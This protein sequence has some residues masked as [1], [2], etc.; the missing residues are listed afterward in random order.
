MNSR[1]SDDTRA[2]LIE[3]ADRLVYQKGFKHTSLADI[4]RESSVPL[5]NVYYHF[6]TKDELG[7]ALVAQR[8]ASYAQRRREWDELT[9]PRQRIQA[10]IQ[11]TIDSSTMLARSGCPIGSLCQELH[12]EG[13]PMA[14]NAAAMFAGFLTWLETQFRAMHKGDEAMALSVHLL[15]A[16]EGA[17]LLTH[18]FN[19]P[20]Y[21]VQEATR[22][23]QWVETL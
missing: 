11:M 20:D 23:M 19:T 4:S 21:I 22:L 15:S 14:E 13:G 3:S 2:R 6:K 5:G 16:L 7:M 8:A 12:K 1:K 18:S 10:F 9:E 17:A